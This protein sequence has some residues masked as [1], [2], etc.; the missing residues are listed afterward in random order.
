M[1]EVLEVLVEGGKVTA[2]PPLG[3]ALGPLG[4]NIMKVI[5]DVNERTKQFEGMKV[6]VKL[7]IDPVTKEYT[8]EVGTPPTTA[9]ILKELGQEKGSG[10]VLRTK[11]GDITLDQ[12]RKIAELKKESLLGKTEKERV[13]EVLGT[14]ISMG[15]T[16]EGKD[17]REVQKAIKE[18]F[19]DGYFGV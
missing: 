5:S 17:P 1:V 14:C 19:H 3:P 4:L 16:V 7:T 13:L 12:L 9:L 15:V 6:P 11:I 10:D 2:G 8:I 18:G